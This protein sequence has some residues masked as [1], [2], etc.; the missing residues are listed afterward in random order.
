MRIK[1][2]DLCGTRMEMLETRRLLAAHVWTGAVSSLWSDAGNWQGGAPSLGESDIR[3]EFP[4]GAQR[5]SS[6][7]D[8]GDLNLSQL[9]LG[10]GSY[11]IGGL[12]FTLSGDVS[13]SLLAGNHRINNDIR[14][15]GQPRFDISGISSTD[16]LELTLGGILS[17][18]GGL[19][20]YGHNLRLLGNNTYTGATRIEGGAIRIDGDQP[21]SN[22]II[23]S[24]QLSGYGT[25]GDVAF[26]FRF[27]SLGAPVQPNSSLVFEGLPH[28]TGNLLLTDDSFFRPNLG[29]HGGTLVVDGV[30]NL[31][32]A[33]LAAVY[34][35][36]PRPGE[37]FVLVANAGTDPI[38]GTFHGLPEGSQVTILDRVMTITYQGGDGNDIAVTV[39]G[40]EIRTIVTMQPASTVVLPGETVS[41]DVLVETVFP[42]DI[43]PGG[44]VRLFQ[45][46]Q[47][48]DEAVLDG[49]G[50]A[51]FDVN[52]LPLRGSSRFHVTYS[53]DAAQNL[54][55]G[56]SD[57]Q[58]VRVILN[59]QT[60]TQLYLDPPSA[61]AG[62]PSL[63][64]ARV[65]GL[66]I[67][68]GTPTGS[69]TFFIDGQAVATRPLDGEGR[70][71]FSTNA[72]PVGN[73]MVR[74]VYSGDARFSPSAVDSSRLTR[75]IE[76]RYF[77]TTTRLVVNATSSNAGEP[78]TLTA[79]VEEGPGSFEGVLTGSV[80][81]YNG[82][83]VLGT[84]GL[85]PNGRAIL[86]VSDLPTGEHRLRAEYHGSEVYYRSQSMEVPHR[87]VG[88][89]TVHPFGD[90][91]LSAVG[92]ID[93]DGHPDLIWHNATT[94]ANTVQFL[95]EQGAVSRSLDL[96]AL[97]DSR[98]KLEAAADF[99]GNGQSDLV[100]RNEQT[101]RILM[102]QIG[103]DQ[104]RGIL[105]VNTTPVLPG[106]RIVGTGDFNNDGQSDIAWRNDQTG[107]AVVWHM[108]NNYVRGVVGLGPVARNLEW[109]MET[110]SDVDG[111]GRPD[112]VWRNR[113]TGGIA[114]WLMR[115][116]AFLSF[117]P[118]GTMRG[119]GW[120]IAAVTDLDSDGENDILFRNAASGE[121][122][123][124]KVDPARLS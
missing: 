25:V 112:L 64:I 116:T 107:Q 119:D 9:T 63:M 81:F 84:A 111:D 28:I 26:D 20:K 52:S 57:Q 86:V 108:R 91:A 87:V 41:I 11:T 102:W 80:T 88:G 24:G 73:V 45:D 38:Q 23:E 79:V 35:T 113:S 90:A 48:I 110:V 49:N 30:V 94:G 10:N 12:A 106:W 122:R 74:A 71:T 67:P 6:T 7:N 76:G 85:R 37:T 66:G 46:G 14:L 89:P 97:K 53:G 93:G 120:G 15:V 96:L 2:F 1:T 21:Q 70:A 43:T 54:E 100:W 75:L 50:R 98:W 82:D 51:R 16:G 55:P 32:G 105:T 68:E 36:P 65:L 121:L 60:E 18:N 5:F 29:V 4:A 42:T 19:V 83:Q 114:A 103:G 27:G 99:S 31:N 58:R 8:I 109:T 22:V 118:L 62:D 95:D 40:E 101:G 78:I 123:T 34:E 17:G 13:A 124:W 61:F 44:T 117:N 47:P 33:T 77:P 69:V 59:G 39:Q 115:G 3:L 72:F 92:D 56:H 104:V